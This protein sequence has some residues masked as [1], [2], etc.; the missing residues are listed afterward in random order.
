MRTSRTLTAGLLTCMLI[1]TSA[2]AVSAKPAADPCWPERRLG[3]ACESTKAAFAASDTLIEP[4]PLAEP[5]AL[6]P[7]TYFGPLGS[8]L[9]TVTVPDGW[10]WLYDILWAD[11]D[12]RADY[13]QVGG[14]GEIALGW[15]EVENVFADPCHWQ[16]SLLGPPVGPTVDDLANAFAAQVG[17]AGSTTDVM[18]GGYPAQ[19]VELSTPADLDV[20][21][22][23][24][25][26]YREFLSPGGSL[27]VAPGAEETP[28]VGGQ[29]DVLYI[30]DVDGTRSVLRTWH[31]PDASAQHLADLEAML[32]SVVID[33]PE[34]LSAVP[35]ASPLREGSLPAGTYTVAPFAGP[36]GWG[37]CIDPPQAGCSESTGDDP[38]TFTF[39]LPDG[40]AGAPFDTLW[41]ATGNNAAP[42]G[43]GLAFGRGGGLYSDPCAAPPPPDIAVGPSVDDF[44][45]ALAAHPLLDA[46]TP[47][48]V[49]LGGHSG[50]YVELQVPSDVSACPAGYYAWEP[51]L[52]AQ[53][54]DQRWYLWILDVDGVRIVVQAMD[55]PGT[56]PERQAELMAIVESI[57]IEPRSQPDAPVVAA[58][59]RLAIGEVADDGARIVAVDTL[60]ARTRDLTI[61]SPSVGTVQVRLLLPAGFGVDSGAVWPVLYLLHGYGQGYAS[62]TDLTD[63]AALTAPT[64]LLVVMPDADSGWYSDAWN[65]GEGGSPAWETFHTSE[66]LQLLERN[67]GAGADRVVAGLSMGGLGAMDYAARHPGMFKAAASYSGVLDTSGSDMDGGEGVFGDPIAQADVWT[68]HNPVELAS[69]LEGVALYVSY[70]DGQPGPLDPVGTM[71]SDIELWVAPQN[72]AFVS[73]LEEL[74][75]PV[76]VDAYGPG[77]HEWSYWERALHQSLPMLLQALDK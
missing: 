24:E 15:W 23:D 63:V 17:R 11:L 69:A 53:G 1:A 25:G 12:G 72:E 32:G 57:R 47:V 45:D 58:V 44:A 43:A 39:S 60:D 46:S 49:I 38:I 3:E 42:A 26:V 16:G 64:D 70:G 33:V 35:P 21:T 50:K 30:L 40:W 68:A 67:W 28:N 73:R 13:R 62:W 31:R 9:W 77:T 14:P 19:K 61:E 2:L 48:D 56:S 54:P 75:I 8:G 7:G 66:L 22:C 71:P 65:D 5:G 34:S 37:V 59:P 18:L 6:A 27:S 51:G 20:T 55:Y 74:G 36:D 10:E 29:V 4:T 41:L 52:R 76:T